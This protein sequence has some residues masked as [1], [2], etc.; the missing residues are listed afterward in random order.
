[1]TDLDAQQAHAQ[2]QAHQ[3]QYV[4]DQARIAFLEQNVANISNALQHTQNNIPAPVPQQL[5]HPNLNLPP[6]PPFSG[7]PLQLPTFKM[8]LIHFLVGNRNTYPDSE[9]QLL[10]VGQLLGLPSGCHQCPCYVPI[11]YE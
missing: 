11:L 6:P 8:K 5:F 10:Y 7:S 3:N 2:Q 4:Q 1:M 9:S